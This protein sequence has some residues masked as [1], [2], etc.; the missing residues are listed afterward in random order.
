MFAGLYCPADFVRRDQMA[1]FLA[2]AA[3]LGANAPVANAQTAGTAFSFG[4]RGPSGY[5][6]SEVYTRSV[7][8]TGD[9]VS[10]GPGVAQS[11]VTTPLTFC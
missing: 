6:R 9:A 4:G 10:N 2:R 1:S 8:T 3:G 5:L 7:A 11:A